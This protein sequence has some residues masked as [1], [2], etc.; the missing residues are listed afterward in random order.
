MLTEAEAKK[1]KETAREYAL[2]EGV[3]GQDPNIS[4]R[5]EKARRLCLAFHSLVDELTEK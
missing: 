3:C 4:A 1:I 5:H 2:A